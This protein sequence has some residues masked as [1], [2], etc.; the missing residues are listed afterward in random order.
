V[1]DKWTAAMEA[2]ARKQL[3][4]FDVIV[5]AFPFY[6]RTKCPYDFDETLVMNTATGWAE[7]ESTWVCGVGVQVQLST[8][9]S[10]AAGKTAGGWTG[11]RGE[12]KVV[13]NAAQALC[14][15]VRW[16]VC[17]PP[18]PAASTHPPAHPAAAPIRIATLLC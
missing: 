11:S 18:Q 12:Q 16:S 5:F 8:V 4:G 9:C 10:C 2:G 14:L 3:A 15:F 7:S 13:G 6:N 1:R 17:L